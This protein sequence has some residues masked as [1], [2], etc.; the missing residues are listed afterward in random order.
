[1]EL[2]PQE[3]CDLGG[4]GGVFSKLVEVKECRGSFKAL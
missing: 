1:M 4:R 2:G 3:P